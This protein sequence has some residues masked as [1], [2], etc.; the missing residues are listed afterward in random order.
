MYTIMFSRLCDGEMFSNSYTYRYFIIA[1]STVDN[2]LRDYVALPIK[3]GD[4]WSIT[5]LYNTHT[6]LTLNSA[7]F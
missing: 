3:D 1:M 6:I 7:M 4:C 2:I 5:V